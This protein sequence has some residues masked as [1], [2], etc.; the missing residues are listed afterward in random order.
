MA[1]R[2]VGAEWANVGAELDIRSSV[3]LKRREDALLVRLLALAVS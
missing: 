3:W 2:V 1:G